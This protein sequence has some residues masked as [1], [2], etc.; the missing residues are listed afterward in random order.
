MANIPAHSLTQT[1]CARPRWTAERA[2]AS[3]RLRILAGY[4]LAGGV[5]MA[6]W[7]MVYSLVSAVIG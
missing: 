4:S 2:P 6:I 1:S 7:V 5:S 3:R